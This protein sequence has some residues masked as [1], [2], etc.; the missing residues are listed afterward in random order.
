MFCILAVLILRNSRN[1][2][3]IRVKTVRKGKR[4]PGPT[5]KFLIGNLDLFGGYESP[6]QAFGVLKE[7][8]GNVFSLQMGTV[9]AV[10]VN[11]YANIKEVLLTKGD[12]FDARPNFH[13]FNI[14]FND[15]KEN[16]KLF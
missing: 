4:L 1:P 2:S 3:D 5:K 10:V 9:P 16:C 8:Y 7:K 13:R 6:F 15:D 12:K 11:G 14:L